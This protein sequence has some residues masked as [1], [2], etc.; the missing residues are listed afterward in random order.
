MRLSSL[1]FTTLRD[2]PSD[3][4]MPSHRLLLRAAL[5]GLADQWLGQPAARG[6]L[7]PGLA[8]PQHVQ[9]DPPD[10]GGQPG[11]QVIDGAGVA[12]APA[13]QPMRVASQPIA[14]A[15]QHIT[16]ASQS[17]TIP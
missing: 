5:V 4:E 14:T 17:L 12:M 3:A 15:G 9:A 1:F 2:D 16:G 8:G 6:V 13:G 7:A 11:P 10:H